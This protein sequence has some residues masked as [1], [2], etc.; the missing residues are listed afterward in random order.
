MLISNHQINW[1]NLQR[2][3]IKLRENL[4]WSVGKGDLSFWFDKWASFG[5]IADQDNVVI[6]WPEVTVAEVL[7]DYSILDQLQ[8]PDTISQAILRMDDTNPEAERMEYH[9]AIKVGLEWLGIE[10]DTVKSTTVLHLVVFGTPY[11]GC[12]PN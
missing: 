7:R 10:F 6:S 12:K 3:G 1:K 9:A 5:I 11:P 8:L 2:A 4:M